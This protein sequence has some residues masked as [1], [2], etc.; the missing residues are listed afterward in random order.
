MTKC[1]HPFYTSTVKVGNF[2]RAA[3]LV[4]DYD[5]NTYPHM[6]TALCRVVRKWQEVVGYNAHTTKNIS[7]NVL[8]QPLSNDCDCYRC[9]VKTQHYGLACFLALAL[10]NVANHGAVN[11]MTVSALEL[12]KSQV[13]HM[14]KRNK[15]NKREKPAASSDE[16]L[17]AL[18]PQIVFADPDVIPDDPTLKPAIEEEQRLQKQMLQQW[19]TADDN[20]YTKF[21][22][23]IARLQGNTDAD[24]NVLNLSQYTSPAFKDLLKSWTAE[25]V[26]GVQNAPDVESLYSSQVNLLTALNE[27][28]PR[29][30]KRLPTTTGGSSSAESSDDTSKSIRRQQKKVK[31]KELRHQVEDRVQK[32]EEENAKLHAQVAE[33][34]EKIAT[35]EALVAQM[36]LKQTLQPSTDA[37]ATPP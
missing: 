36:K 18:I 30:A 20:T 24:G 31:V 26:A 12:V 29:L 4:L 6:K 9:T 34:D 14:R 1:N 32:L 11:L 21:W 2:R 22:D 35:L 17:S 37:S 8:S 7:L 15:K 27:K 5:R 23:Q 33:R 28:F 13:I 3:Q 10:T 25:L 19:E 16:E